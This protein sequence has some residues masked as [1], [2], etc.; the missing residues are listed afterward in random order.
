MC[1][2]CW[3]EWKRRL[4][5]NSRRWLFSA[6]NMTHTVFWGQNLHYHKIMY[7]FIFCL[8]QGADY[9]SWHFSNLSYIVDEELA[10]PAES[11]VVRQILAGG[12]IRR[13]GFLAVFLRFEECQKTIK[14]IC[15]SFLPR[16]WREMNV[17]NMNE[18]WQWNKLPGEVTKCPSLEIFK[19]KLGQHCVVTITVDCYKLEGLD[20]MTYKI[21]FKNLHASWR[22]PEC[23]IN[24]SKQA[25]F[26]EHSSKCYPMQ[27]SSMLTSREIP[28]FA[29]CQRQ[30]WSFGF[31]TISSPEEINMDKD[32]RL[33][34]MA[35][36]TWRNQ[37]KG[38]HFRL[39]G[40]E[41]SRVTLRTL[42]W[43]WASLSG[44]EQNSGQTC[45]G[46]FS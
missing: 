8:S 42:S 5:W 34:Q 18:V 40:R 11:A 41:I 25:F 9:R 31:L 15:S 33:T 3:E 44:L 16:K 28:R 38:N 43:D 21:F 10:H 20:Q 35:S 45:L 46:S 19:K 22:F 12:G 7:N 26:L 30:D 29:V 13:E 4:S 24:L 36:M 37:C 2:Y 27:W 39:V 14:Y 17:L 1:V 6:Q 32:K 23:L